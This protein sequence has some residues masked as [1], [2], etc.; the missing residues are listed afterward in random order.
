[1]CQ[2]GLDPQ[3]PS[4]VLEFHPGACSGNCP[5]RFTKHIVQILTAIGLDLGGKS[6]GFPRNPQQF[7]LFAG[8][9]AEESLP[10]HQLTL[11]L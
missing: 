10:F 4:L 9:S 8:G 1:M 2:T 6:R 3:N 11:P 5:S 7:K